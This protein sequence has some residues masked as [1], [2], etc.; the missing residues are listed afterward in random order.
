MM[1]NGAELLL[2]RKIA[3]ENKE[4]DEQEKLDKAKEKEA[5]LYSKAEDA[6]VI[7][8]EKGHLLDQLNVPELQNIVRFLCCV[9][10]RGKGD[11]FSS[12]GKNK[13]TLKAR[14]C[15]V[16][17]VWTK[18]FELAPVAEEEEDGEEENEVEESDEE[19]EL[20]VMPRQRKSRRLSSISEGENE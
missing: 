6:Y 9:E 8:C 20:E 18:Y 12:H 19:A 14:I 11:T 13:N 16:E 3:R 15:K 10:K 4:K 1:Y 7:F 2:A 5:A 17:P